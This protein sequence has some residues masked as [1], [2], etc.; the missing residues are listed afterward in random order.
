MLPKIAFHR[1]AG[2]GQSWPVWRQY[3]FYNADFKGILEGY[4]IW[5]TPIQDNFVGRNLVGLL[6]S[7]TVRFGSGLPFAILAEPGLA[8]WRRI[9]GGILRSTKS[10]LGTWLARIKSLVG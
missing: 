6:A 1:G 9:L 5:A 4:V 2:S 8:L 10:T 7:I 3:M